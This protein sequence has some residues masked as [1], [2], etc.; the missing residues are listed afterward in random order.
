MSSVVSKILQMMGYTPERFAQEAAQKGF[1]D[2]TQ[3]QQ[4]LSRGDVSMFQ[5]YARKLAQ[6]NPQM[7]AQAQ[8]QCS[9]LK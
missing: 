9:G 1:G 6:D 4:A 7:A 8:S 2:A 5:G 3:I